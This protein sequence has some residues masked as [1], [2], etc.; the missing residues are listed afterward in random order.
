MPQSPLTAT[1]LACVIASALYAN[2]RPALA[3]EDALVIDQTSVSV[4]TD[5]NVG[6]RVSAASVSGMGAVPLGAILMWSGDPTNLPLGWMLCDG[7]QRPDGTAVPDLSGRFVVGYQ[8][9]S[10]DYAVGQVGGEAKHSLS[11]EEMPNHSH[12]AAIDPAGEHSHT[13][14]GTSYG[15]AFYN[16]VQSGDTRAD[17][18]QNIPTS[19]AGQHA[20]S[21]TIAPTGG[22]QPHENRPP[23]YT[24]AYI[25]Y[26]GP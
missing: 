24:L 20:H 26:V 15:W 5:L 8:A 22:G 10:A 4:A 6:G 1:A 23:F 25:I 7:S 21:L 9:G 3:Q 17:P 14:I 2:S 16:S 12:T 19:S 13:I 11:V 18:I